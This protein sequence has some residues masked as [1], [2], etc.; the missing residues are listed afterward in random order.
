VDF[1]AIIA[2]LDDLKSIGAD[3]LIVPMPKPPSAPLQAPDAILDSFDELIRQASTRGIRILVNFPASGVTADLPAIARFWLSRGVAGFRMVTPPETSPEISQSVVEIVR[4]TASSAVGERIVITDFNPD[5]NSSS[6]TPHPGSSRRK[7]TIHTDRDATSASAQLQVASR[8]NE[9]ELPG[10]ANVRPLLEQSLIQPNVLLDFHPPSPPTSPDPYPALANVMAAIVLTTHSAALIDADHDSAL[11]S[12]MQSTSNAPAADSTEWYR[13]LNALR[14]SNPTLRYGS[15][16]VLNFDEQNAIVWVIR[17]GRGSGRTPP[18][19]V[20]C[21][22]SASPVQI[23]LG[24]AT[25]RLNLRGTF[26]RTLL[27]SD[28]AMGAHY[29]NSLNLPPFGVYIGELRR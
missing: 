22:L 4:Q 24:A 8:L 16:T 12:M 18:V 10:A 9:L 25:R 15:V 19:V 21:N 23:S 6:Y 13:Q 11:Q 29:L 17:P 5:A 1:K 27:R 20:A 26:L 3:A 7:K 14:H 28:G 2:R